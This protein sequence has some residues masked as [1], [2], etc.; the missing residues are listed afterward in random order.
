MYKR[1]GSWITEFYHEGVRYKKSLG[2]GISKTVAK[3]REAKFKQ[4]IR[5]GKHLQKARRIAFE[6][7]TE[8]YLSNAKVN[9]RESSAKRN[10]VSIKALT[11]FFRGVLLQDINSFQAEQFKKARREAGVS[12]ATVN[13]DLACLR[14]MLN[15]AVEWSYL[16][17]N[18]IAKVKQLREANESKMWVITEE[19]E[20][21]LLEECDRRPQRKK[22]LR[23]LTAFA[24][25]SGMRQQE[26]FGLLKEDVHLDDNYLL[27]RDSKTHE[28]RTVPLNDTLKE[29]LG[30]VLKEPGEYVF[31]NAEGKKLTV[32]TNAYWE[33]IRKAGLTNGNVRF[34]FHDLRHSFGSRL[35]MN[36][37][38]LKTIMQVMG[39]KAVR[40]AMRYQHP[41]PSHRLEAVRSLDKSGKILTP[42]VTPLKKED[43]EKAISAMV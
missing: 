15:K 29:I 43:Q 40:V 38:D 21:R 8:K 26:I 30:K 7:F 23:D 9:K 18:P 12:P 16:R 25:Y 11:P 31:T 4:E 28:S 3:E 22:Y 14:N 24:L 17:L 19:E 20:E 5:E 13:R 10:E 36:G 1:S 39:H 2:M 41:N 32:L 6:K 37:V 27:V 42:K 34:R 33:A 35:G